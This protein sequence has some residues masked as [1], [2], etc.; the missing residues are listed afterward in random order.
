MLHWQQY[1][2]FF[3]ENFALLASAIVYIAIVLNA[4]Q[5]GLATVTI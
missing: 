4:M 5:V 1:G 2:T 3:Q